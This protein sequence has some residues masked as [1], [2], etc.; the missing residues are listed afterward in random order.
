M[1]QNKLLKRIV[2]FLCLAVMSASILSVSAGAA[3][4][5]GPVKSFKASSAKDSVKLKWAKLKGASG[6]NIYQFD[7]VSA[8]KKIAVLKGAS[9]RS[10]TVKGLTESKPYTFRIAAYNAAGEGV[11]SDPK[12]ATPKTSKPGTV[13]LKLRANGNGFVTLYWKRTA[14]TSGYEVL[15]KRADGTYKSLGTTTKKEITIKNLRNG[16]YYTFVVRAYRKSGKKKVYGNLSNEKIGK[17]NAPKL[18]SVFYKDTGVHGI[19]YSAKM[20]KQV[21]VGGITFKKGQKVTVTNA[22][23]VQAKIL[24]NKTQQI[25]VPRN[26]VSLN[27]LV[28]DSKTPYTKEQAEAYVNGKG[29]ASATEYL[30]FVSLYKQHVHVFKGSKYHWTQIGCY[31]C[32]SGR[33]KTPTTLGTGTCPGKVRDWIFDHAAHAWWA[34]KLTD[35]QA[36]HSILLWRNSNK[37]ADPTLGKPSSHGCVRLAIK[38]AKWIYENVPTGT[39]NIRY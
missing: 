6:Y 30:I 2:L 13:K 32:A 23:N 29:Y 39:F 19:W 24:V 15:Q 28:T 5:P 34:T 38:N 21:T 36:I 37:V 25:A 1:S 35:G 20:T 3:A 26:S 8:Y 10:Y 27:G 14:N 22:N 18:Q 12:S 33:F 4:A 17:P 9:K 16:E 31:K 11:L 7:G